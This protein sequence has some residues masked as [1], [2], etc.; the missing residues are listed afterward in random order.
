[1]TLFQLLKFID[2]ESKKLPIDANLYTNIIRATLDDKVLILLALNS[3][4]NGYTKYKELI[5]KYSFFEHLDFN[6]S[7]ILHKN[8]EEII[9]GKIRSEYHL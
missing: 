9:A 4:I 2:T 8:V 6:L 1:M 5:I 3:V 7:S